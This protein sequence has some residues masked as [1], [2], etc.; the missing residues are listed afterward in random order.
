MNT[1][2]LVHKVILLKITQLC[3]RTLDV[4]VRA[5]VQQL[6]MR[7]KERPF[8]LGRVVDA[9][10]NCFYDSVL[11]Q[12]RIKTLRVGLAQ[13]AEHIRTYQGFNFTFSFTTA[14]IFIPNKSL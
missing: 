11:A 9:Y 3:F 6:L 13:R 1:D 10:G 5:Q 2:L 4:S 7:L 12:L 14:V 8:E